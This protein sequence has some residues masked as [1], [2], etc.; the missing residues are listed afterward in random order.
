M[1]LSVRFGLNI[2]VINVIA[3]NNAIIVSIS[4]VNRHNSTYICKS[5]HG[6]QRRHKPINK[7]ALLAKMLRTKGQ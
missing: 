3:N 4:K 6:N 2:I 5:T 1:P 7:D